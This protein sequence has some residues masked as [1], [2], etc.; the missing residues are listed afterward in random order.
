MRA[1]AVQR[2]ARVGWQLGARGRG[3]PTVTALRACLMA[4]RSWRTRQESSQGGSAAR[5]GCLPACSKSASTPAPCPLAYTR[6]IK[7][8]IKDAGLG[9]G[10]YGLLDGKAKGG[11]AKSGD[12][13][14]VMVRLERHGLSGATNN[15][16]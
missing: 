8:L 6:I 5:R 2:G 15:E 11:G 4:V 14:H 12:I 13:V 16:P 3:W 9:H 1:W 10:K 7:R